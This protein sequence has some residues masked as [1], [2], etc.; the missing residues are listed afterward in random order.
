[1][2][3]AAIEKQTYGTTA[4]G[5]TVDEYTLTNASGMEVRIITY[6][7]IIASI[8]TPDRNGS[9]AGV[10]LGFDTLADYTGRHPYFGA[11]VGRYGNRI[12][13]AKFTLDGK[14]Y[15][16]ATNDGSNS[17]H[18][19]LKGFDKAIWAAK[20]IKGDGEVGLKLSFVSPDGDEGYPGNLSVTVVY[21]LTADNSLRIDYHATTD[22]TTVVNLTNHTYFNLGGNGSGSVYDQIIQIDADHYTP[23][24]EKLIPT[25]ELA[26]VEG[27]PFDFRT[28]KQIGGGIRS[29]DAQMVRGRG[30]DHNFVINRQDHSSL[31]K[32]VWVYAPSTGRT[33][34]VWTT[35]PGVQFYTANFLDGTLVGSSGGMYRQGDALCL[36]TQHFPDSPNQPNFPSTTL[37]PGD[38][39]K[40]TTVYEFGTD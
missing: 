35:E 22:K 38:T 3:T 40:S 14:E 12:G 39:Y 2:A 32:A 30:Y 13:A 10:T 27:T 4:A 16:L 34:E 26:P 11:L 31:A 21:T 28:P 25:G 36:E 33:M 37:K 29:G 20:E 17:L 15:K 23:V 5:A 19:G 7:G 8:R 9:L 1:M 18:G 24:N 6:G